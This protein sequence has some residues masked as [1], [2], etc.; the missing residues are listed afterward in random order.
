MCIAWVPDLREAVATAK[1]GH[2]SIKGMPLFSTRNGKPLSYSTVRGWWLK[3]ISASG[4]KDGR[5]RDIRAKT[6]T[7]AK[8][9]EINSEALL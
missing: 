4:I 1:T 6:G 8:K 3:A 5:M 7:D 2:T 9:R